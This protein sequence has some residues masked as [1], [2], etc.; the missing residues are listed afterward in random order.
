MLSEE[1][2]TLAVMK[3][4]ITLIQCHLFTIIRELQ[5][6]AIGHDLSKFQEDEFSGFVQINKIA[7]E[8][9]YGSDEYKASLKEVDAVEL[10]YSRNDH[11]P[12]YFSDGISDMNLFQ[13]IEMVADWKAASE[14]Y[15]QTSFGESLRKQRKRFNINE[16]QFHVIQLIA[17]SLS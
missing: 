13:L 10:H 5:R 6:R 16:K 3:N 1:A 11:H 17:E 14:A 9:P 15:G 12:E 8:Y 4:H 7:R 2:K